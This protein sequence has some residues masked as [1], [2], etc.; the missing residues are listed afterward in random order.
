MSFISQ[1]ESQKCFVTYS[2]IIFDCIFKIIQIGCVHEIGLDAL[3]RCHL[4]EETIGS[5]VDIV[6]R[7]NVVAAAQ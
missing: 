2:R 3:T 7:Y 4:R 1:I 6:A 5:A